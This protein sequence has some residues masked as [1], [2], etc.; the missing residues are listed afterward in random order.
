MGMSLNWLRLIASA[1]L[2]CASLN[3]PL[4]K[5]FTVSDDSDYFVTSSDNYDFIYSAAFRPYVKALQDQNRELKT[6]YQKEF[7]WQLDEKASLILASPRNQIANGFA[8]LFPNLHTVFYGGGAELIDDFSVTSWARVLL[9]HETA[10]LYQ[11]NVKQ[12]YSILL[13]KYLGNP[14]PNLVPPFTYM[15]SPS[16]FLPTFILEGNATFNEGRFGNGGRLYSGEYR[17]LFL[18]LLRAEKI[19]STRLINDH[20]EWP[21]GQEKYLVGGY[22][23]LYLAETYGIQKTNEFFFKN[24]HYF[25]L[26][27]QLKKSFIDTFGVGYDAAIKSFIER[28]RPLAAEMQTVAATTKIRSISHRGLARNPADKSISFLTSNGKNLPVLHELTGTTTALNIKKKKINIPLGE[29]IYLEGRL[30]TASSETVHHNQVRMGLYSKNYKIRRDSLDHFV[31][32]TYKNKKVY[33]FIPDSFNEPQI[34]ESDANNSAKKYIGTAQ[35]SPLYA[36]NGDILYFRQKGTERTLMKNS[37]PLISYKGHYGKVVDALENG[38]VYFVAASERGTSLYRYTQSKIERVHTADTIVD[39]KALNATDWVVAEITSNGYEY[40]VVNDLKPIQQAPHYYQY[41]YED[42]KKKT[43]EADL[44]TKTAESTPEE[45]YSSIGRMR[46]NGVD[47]FYLGWTEYG[48][49]FGFAARFADPLQFNNVS[50]TYNHLEGDTNDMLLLYA[51]RK[52]RLNWSIGGGLDQSAIFDGDSSSSDSKVLARYETW[53]GLLELNYP[54]FVLPQ[55]SGT[56]NTRYSYEY[57]DSDDTTV[58][59]DREQSV[60]TYFE[61]SRSRAYPIAYLP[62]AQD[63]F[64]LAH[65]ALGDIPKWQGDRVNY[66]AL[67]NFS[68]DLGFENYLSVGY[69][70]VRS[71]SPNGDIEIDQMSSSGL[72]TRLFTPTELTRYSEDTGIEFKEAHKVSVGYQKAINFSYYFKR[73]PISLRRLAPFAVYQEFYTRNGTQKGLETLFHEWAYGAEFE[74]LLFHRTPIRISATGVEMNK[75]EGTAITTM[76]SFK[77]NF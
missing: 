20:I 47:P 43:P 75:R 16:I 5:A 63:Q 32:D 56:L 33:A 41:F 19:N 13:N 11:L 48:G 28:Y 37:Q 18:N 64:V 17:A 77:D 76:V 55:V 74:L 66:G 29:P 73:F 45:P 46:F 62:A 4:A 31:Y 70:A 25:L 59:L 36:P 3:A 49:I 8:T 1:L 53:L 44:L 34:Y 58:R 6:V 2:I 14:L 65:E 12:D 60:L 30:Y 42:E 9:L 52:H 27:F 68:R 10:H 15:M 24:A 22:F 38:D 51:N 21:Y 35:S 69:H 72:S 23:Q 61:L 67:V 71:D 26:P 7:L 40:K 54:L 50:F 39:A 57:D